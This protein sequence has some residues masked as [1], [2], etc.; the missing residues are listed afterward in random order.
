MSTLASSFGETLVE[1]DTSTIPD[2]PPTELLYKHRVRYRDAIR[3]LFNHR[4]IIYTL[5][6][7]DFRAQ[8]KQAALGVLWAILGPVATL[9]LFVLVFSRVKPFG[10][11]GIPYPLYAFIGLLCWNF[12][13]S[14]LGNGGN[15]LLSNKALLAK[16]QFPRECF[17]LETM[18]VQAI[19]TMISWIPLTLLFVIFGR[20]PKLASVWVPMYMVIEIA[21]AAGIALSISSIIIQM[22]DLVQILPLMTTLG[23]FATP[24]I[25]P[26]YDIPTAYHVAGGTLVHKAHVGGQLIHAHW[27][28]GFTVNLQMVYGFFNPLGPVIAGA[29]DTMLLGHAPNWPLVGI[30]SLGAVLYLAIGYRVFKRLEEHFADI[31]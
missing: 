30:A 1:P 13:A 25:W 3:N 29:R 18:G 5:A 26:F 8:Y 9:I 15:S 12:F 27:V 31:A 16:T 4:E 23:L 2:E 20:A 19:N 7:R 10:S 21:F 14:A 11:E 6:E 24:V 17:P 28:G 22:R